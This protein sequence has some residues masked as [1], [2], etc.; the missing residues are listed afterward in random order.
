MFLNNFSVCNF[1]VKF[2]EFLG[3]MAFF[4]NNSLFLRHRVKSTQ[5]D[6]MGFLGHSI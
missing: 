3:I 2:K 6:C 5:P 1:F 4:F